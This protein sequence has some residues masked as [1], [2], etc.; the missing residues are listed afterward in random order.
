M[1]DSE[2]KVD[3]KLTGDFAGDVTLTKNAS[4]EAGE[5]VV[6]NGKLAASSLPLMTTD[7]PASPQ[8]HS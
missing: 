7:S 5:S 3:D 8:R 4:V 2:V 1:L 6:I